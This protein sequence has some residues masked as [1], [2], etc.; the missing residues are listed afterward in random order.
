[1]SIQSELQNLFPPNIIK[2]ATRL[3]P[4]KVDALAVNA[5]AGALLRL[6]GQPSEQVALVSTMQPSTA[7]ALC[8]WLIDPSFWG[9]VSNVTT[10]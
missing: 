8:R 1:M 9:L 5:A 10:H 6:K 4:A 2:Q 3:E 7:A